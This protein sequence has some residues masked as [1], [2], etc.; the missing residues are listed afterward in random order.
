MSLS[1]LSQ[2]SYDETDSMS[3]ENSTEISHTESDTESDTD[4]DT[5]RGDSA[6]SESDEDSEEEDENPWA[7][8]VENVWD[9]YEARVRRK[10]NT[11]MEED[12]SMSREE[13]VNVAIE[14]YLPDMNRTLGQKFIDFSVLTRDFKS[15]PVH[16][17]IMKTAKRAREEDDMDW[18]ESVAHAARKRRL[19]LQRL[20]EEHEP[21]IFDEEEEDDSDLED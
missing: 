14:A 8:W 17:K 15:D 12:D 20:L 5:E 10:I 19:L 9:Q 16:Q 11:L 1:E 13:A 3:E 4:S 6:S 7:V 21:D 18:E 2:K